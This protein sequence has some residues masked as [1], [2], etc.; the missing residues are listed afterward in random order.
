MDIVL[1]GHGY[2]KSALDMAFWDILGKS[3]GL[4]LCDLWGGRFDAPIIVSDSL[5]IFGTSLEGDIDTI[6]QED[7]R[8]FKQGHNRIVAMKATGNIAR[9]IE[10]IDLLTSE[11]GPEFLFWVDANSGWRFTEALQIGLA[12]HDRNIVYEQPCATYEECRQLAW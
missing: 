6:V 4:A 10:I 8:R 9:D 2:A 1:V 5:S 7:I 11:L 3:V 12:L